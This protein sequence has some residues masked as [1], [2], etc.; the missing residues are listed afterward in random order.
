MCI[1][2]G[3]SGHGGD[4]GIVVRE[5]WQLQLCS[6]SEVLCGGKWPRRSSAAANVSRSE[7]LRKVVLGY[8]LQGLF[9]DLPELDR[10]VVGG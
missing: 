1:G 8:D 4:H 7:V 5:T 2:I 10:L 6:I 9:E 3:A